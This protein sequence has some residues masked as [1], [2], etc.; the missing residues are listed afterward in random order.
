MDMAVDS[1]EVACAIAY[2]QVQARWRNLLTGLN[3]TGGDVV[4]LIMLWKM[5]DLCEEIDALPRECK[6]VTEKVGGDP[7]ISKSKAALTKICSHLF[8]GQFGE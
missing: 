7:W 8:G 1:G 2:N 3:G 4:T 6:C 5:I